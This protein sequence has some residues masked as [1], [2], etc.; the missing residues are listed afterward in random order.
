MYQRGPAV[1]EVLKI[2]KIMKHFKAGF[3]AVLHDGPELVS[4]NYLLL[5]LRPDTGRPHR[6]LSRQRQHAPGC[7]G[8]RE[9]HLS[10]KHYRG[11]LQSIE[12]DHKINIYDLN[13]I[14][15]L[16][17]TCISDCPVTQ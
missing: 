3:Q 8:V 15:K 4:R 14:D 9:L 2:L 10:A 11:A 16:L 13:M 6:H 17:T 5:D 1:Y 7:L 12:S